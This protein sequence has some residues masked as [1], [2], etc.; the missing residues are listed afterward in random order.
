MKG[1]L[2][3]GRL[4]STYLSR[5]NYEYVQDKWKNYCF[6]I[7]GTRRSYALDR[8]HHKHIFWSWCG[9]FI[10]IAATAYLSIKMNSPLL[11][12]PFG[13]TSVLIFGIPDSPLAQPRNVIG[14]NFVAALVSLTILHLFG[15][16]PWAMG[17][18]V[19]T[20]IGMMQL[21]ATL[22]P[23]SG[24]VALVVMMTKASWQFLLTP[25]L[26]GSIILV[27]CAVV[28]NNLAHERTY[29]KYWF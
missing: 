17:M 20:A 23:P 1:Y 10:G 5:F 12:A 19:A 29:P 25:A 27:L 13:A 24:A 6:K 3:K 22:H 14:G 11:M 8:P 28:F 9:S 4:S 15:S 16:E 7:R 26:E 21:T 2:P 18:A